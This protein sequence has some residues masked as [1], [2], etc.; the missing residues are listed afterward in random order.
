M[1]KT[2][3]SQVSPESAVWPIECSLEAL[4]QQALF[5][6]CVVRRLGPRESCSMSFI[7]LGLGVGKQ[8]ELWD[9]NVHKDIQIA[10]PETTIAQSNS[11]LRH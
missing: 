4:L 8:V 9:S 10:F 1:G 11:Q 7:G 6:L 2:T 3:P 5:R